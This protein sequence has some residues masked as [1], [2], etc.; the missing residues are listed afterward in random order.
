[1]GVNFD[2]S[3]FKRAIKELSSKGLD[4]IYKPALS[5]GGAVLKNEIRKSIA[6]NDHTLKDL[7]DMGHPYARRGGQI[8]I[9][10]GQPLVHTRSGRMIAALRVKVTNSRNVRIGF[11]DAIA[12]HAR[13]V[14]SGTKVMLPRDVFRFVYLDE[15]KSISI[16]KAV[17]II[18]QLK[19][20]A[21]YG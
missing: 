19:L 15:K 18:I 8:K 5:A 14:I 16:V 7:E 17:G 13:Y 3:N 4:A 2:S 10:G 11:D 21:K 20:R 6:L 1:M 12:P 9:H